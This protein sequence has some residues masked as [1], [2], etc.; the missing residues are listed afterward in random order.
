MNMDTRPLISVIV[1]V[2]KV[3][4]YLPRCVDSLLA[5][6]YENLEIILVDDGS[7]DN[8][9]SI[10]DEY[11]LRDPRIRVIHKENGGL[12]SARNA[13][14]DIAAGDYLG[15]VDSDDWVVP[16]AY[17]WL[18]GMAL[19]EDVKLVCAGRYDYSSWSQ[20]L[21]TGLCPAKREVIS[22]EELARRIFLWDNVDSAAWDKLYHRR[23][24]R[25]I[26]FPYGMIV[27]D[28]PIM[29]KIVLDA[30]RVA[31]LNKPVYNYY[32]RKGSITTSKISEKTFHFSQH[33]SK[34]LPFIQENHPNLATEASYLRV[35]S[36]AYSVL[37]V[38]LAAPE[39]RK[40]FRD[41]CSQ[42]RK[43]LRGFM[44]FILT[45]P[46]FS[47][48]EKLTDLLLAMGWYRGLRSVKNRFRI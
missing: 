34:I 16:Q 3:E 36:L 9:G 41:V 35:R 19:E 38:D 18:L 10:C 47:R 27:E 14:I 15:F 8:C 45:S 42:E 25:Q 11:A 23:L 24:F 17:E 30:G 32:H 7:P 43:R 48:K 2:Y 26:R 37:S 28:V 20:E 21:K 6:T 4:D 22:G 13:G 46:L 29:Y 33:T 44:G 5:Q 39:D 40:K 31:F 1:P 12:S